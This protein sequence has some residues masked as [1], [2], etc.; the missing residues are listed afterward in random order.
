MNLLNRPNEA[1]AM[2][3]II[4]ML[5]FLESNTKISIN[6]PKIIVK[7]LNGMTKAG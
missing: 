3:I 6:K 1:K 7:K 4:V 5:Y 2:P